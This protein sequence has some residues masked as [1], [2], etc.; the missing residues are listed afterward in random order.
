MLFIAS[1][2]TLTF[3]IGIILSA[4]T[5]WIVND[6]DS[7]HG[8]SEAASLASVWMILRVATYLS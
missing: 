4:T 2:A 6:E 7:L 3:V 5:R 1:L 8:E